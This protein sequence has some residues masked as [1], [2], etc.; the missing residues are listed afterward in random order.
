MKRA[1]EG[2]REREKI[3]ESKKKH[4]NPAGLM[5][6][7]LGEDEM[8]PEMGENHSDPN[9][10]SPEPNTKPPSQPRAQAIV[11]KTLKKTKRG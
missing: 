11:V 6:G 10:I 7:D 9:L 2:K 4:L 5:S 8:V 3:T 1:T